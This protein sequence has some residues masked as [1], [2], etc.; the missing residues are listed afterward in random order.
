MSGT[1]DDID[2]KILDIL[3][4]AGRTRRNDL[5]EAVGLSLPAASERLR[6]LEEHKLIT[7]YYAAL[8]HRRLGND[9]TAFIVVSVDSSRHYGQFIEHAESLDEIMECHAIT[10]EGTHL[11]KVRTCNTASLERLLARIQAWPG[12]HRTHTNLV[13]SS[14]KESTRIK[15][16]QPSTSPR[17]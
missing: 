6:K 10:G 7:G 13:L 17:G 14:A 9:I 11:L 2:L 3:Q 8:D 12:V 16:F 15:F 5:A 1:L 4:K